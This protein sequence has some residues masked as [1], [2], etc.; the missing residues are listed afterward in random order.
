MYPQHISIKTA[1]QSGSPACVLAH[2]PSGSTHSP[3]AFVVKEEDKEELLSSLGLFLL[4][5]LQHIQGGNRDGDTIVQEA[6]PGHLGVDDL[7]AEGRGF[8]KGRTG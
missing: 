8:S 3:G 7:K 4:A 6:L 1:S 2:P 5:Q